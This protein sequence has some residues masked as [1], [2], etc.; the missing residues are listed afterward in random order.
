MKDLFRRPAALTAVA[1]ATLLAVVHGRSLMAHETPSY[2]VLA[3]RE[4]FEV[5][6][7]QPHLVAET[8]VEGSFDAAGNEAFRRLA[9]FIFGKNDGGGVASM[10]AR[11]ATEASA[12]PGGGTRIAM[13][14]PVSMDRRDGRWVMAFPMPSQFTL[15]T[16]PRP[17]D[18]RVTLREAPGEI[19]AALRFSGRGREEAF[20]AKTAL[21]RRALG[22]VGIETVDEPVLARYDA[23][24]TPGF[25]RRNEVLIRLRSWPQ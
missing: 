13:T 1:I 7:Y 23:P 15:E 11:A 12:Q 18:E 6:R 22:E 25:L 19:V 10:T 3:G 2:T 16:L 9:G 21:L 20:V 24:W 17:T 14:V 4:H 8:T 5:R